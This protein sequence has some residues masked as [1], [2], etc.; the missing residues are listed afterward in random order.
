MNKF[1]F[2]ILLIKFTI[3]ISETPFH[4]FYG[5]NITKFSL[6]NYDINCTTCMPAGIKFDNEGNIYVSFPRWFENVYATFALFNKT[7]HLFQPWPSLEENNYND[8]NK[9]NSVL[10]FEIF[11]G[12]IYILDQGRI[13]GSLPKDNSMKLVVYDIK[14]KNRTRTYIFPKEIADPEFA[15]LNDIVIDINRNL[16]YISDSGI[17]IDD[18]KEN[19]PGLIILNLTVTDKINATR[20]LDSNETVM[21]D[22]TFWLHINKTKVK[23]NSPMKT[24]ID[25]IAL[26]CDFNTLFYTPL[27][28]RMLYSLNIDQMLE[29]IKNKSH[30]IIIYS[31]FKK[32]ASDGLLYSSNDNLYITGIESGNI[33]IAKN[34]DDD[35]LRMDYREFKVLKGNIS[36]MW[37]DTLAIYDAKLFWISNQLNNFPHNI[38]FDNPITGHDNFRIFYAEIE[39]DGNYLLGCN[40][41]KINWSFGNIAIWVIFAIA[42]LIFLSFVIMGSNKQEDIIDKNMNLDLKD[43]Y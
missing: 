4:L 7:T 25:G 34:I 9:L 30:S 36:T 40:L 37:P 32:E 35:L 24:G 15:F 5:W 26:S 8:S 6:N 11:N 16:A 43:N 33:Y 39:N 41:M 29:H 42:I 12:T 27:T 17:P 3:Q 19:K 23:E 28:S 13:N 10:G 22:E 20:V 2:Q 21:P 18:K 31:G 14:S 38:N 1:L